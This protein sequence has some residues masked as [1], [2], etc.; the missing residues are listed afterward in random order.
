MKTLITAMAGPCHVVRTSPGKFKVFVREGFL[1]EWLLDGQD[2]HTT[3]FV[4]GEIR[5]I[6]LRAKEREINSFFHAQVSCKLLSL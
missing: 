1:L 6:I 5:P 4:E 3:L 2:L